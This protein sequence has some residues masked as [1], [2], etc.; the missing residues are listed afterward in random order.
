MA[1]DSDAATRQMVRY[2]LGGIETIIGL[3]ALV[4][5]VLM[6]IEPGGEAL[7]LSLLWL[8]KTPFSDYAVPG[9]VLALLFGAGNLFGAFLAFMNYEFAGEVAGFLGMGMMVWVMM[10]VWLFIPTSWIQPTFFT[11]GALQ[12]ILGVIWLRTRWNQTSRRPIWP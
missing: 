7:G 1:N 6:V 2:P 11:L 5:G 4:G 8:G 10:Q 3:T 9:L 12:F